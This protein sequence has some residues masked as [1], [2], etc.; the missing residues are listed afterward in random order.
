MAIQLTAQEYTRIKVAAQSI[1][2]AAAGIAAAQSLDEME[3][4]NVGHALEE[5]LAKAGWIAGV[6]GQ[7]AAR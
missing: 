3:P 7:A 5:V 4:Q 6:L 1:E 2:T